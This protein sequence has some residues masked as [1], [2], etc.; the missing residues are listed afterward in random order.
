MVCHGSDLI[1]EARRAY[2][3]ANTVQQL[4]IAL[5]NLLAVSLQR[6][7]R[8]RAIKRAEPVYAGTCA[9]PRC[10]RDIWQ[11]RYGRTKLYCSH[12]CEQRAYRYRQ[13]REST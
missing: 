4:R 10:G 8:A 6:A 7:D 9:A 2:E 3:Q 13:S 11:S 1:S 12:A 5:G